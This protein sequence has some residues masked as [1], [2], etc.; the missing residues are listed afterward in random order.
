M[1]NFEKDKTWKSL[2]DFDRL[3]TG[4]LETKFWRFQ[5]STKRW[6]EDW[7]ILKPIQRSLMVSL[8]LYAR[9]RAFCYPSERKLAKDLGTTPKTIWKNIKI[10]EKKGFIRI[11]KVITQRGKANR[12]HLLKR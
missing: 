6:F 10:L 7:K 5:L 8:W 3:I 12:Y 2:E 4:N 9:T 11:E 1:E